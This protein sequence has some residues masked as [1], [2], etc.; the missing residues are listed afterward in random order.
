MCIEEEEEEEQ[1]EEGADGDEDP[2]I[3][4]RADANAPL[5]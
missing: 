4:A 5:L 2:I 1:Q 3:A